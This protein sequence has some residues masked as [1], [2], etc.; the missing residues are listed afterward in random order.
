MVARRTV[1]VEI[2]LGTVALAELAA[3]RQGMPVDEWI[4]R[5]ARREFAGVSPG[6]SEYVELT[7]AEMRAEDIE[8]TVDEVMMTA[9]EA[10]RFRAPG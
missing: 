5:A 9:D 10:T 7:E 6:G 8:R 2:D 3:T 4:A 1:P